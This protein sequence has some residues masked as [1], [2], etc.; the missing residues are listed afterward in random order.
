MRVRPI[1]MTVCTTLIGLLPI[2]FG[3]ETG[4]EVMKRIATPMVGGLF[5]AAVLTLIVV[6]A[7]YAVVEGMRHRHVFRAG[8]DG[9]AEDIAE[10]A[11]VRAST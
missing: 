9:E 6:P 1:L 4:A 7:I 3:S 5:S 8:G 2:M 10:V 11:T